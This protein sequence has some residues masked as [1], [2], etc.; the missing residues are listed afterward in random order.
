MARK[1]KAMRKADEDT[2][3]AM[4]KRISELVKSLALRR[5]I[6][7][8]RLAEELGYSRVGFN[9]I[10]NSDSP[11]R[12][13][14]LPGL[15]AISRVFGVPL[16]DVIRVAEGDAKIGIQGLPLVFVISGTEPRT[17]ERLICLVQEALQESPEANKKLMFDEGDA[18]ASLGCRPIELKRGA[19]DFYQGY[20]DGV[21]SDTDAFSKLRSAVKY[22]S[23]HGGFAK[24]PLWVAIGK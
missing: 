15:C 21:I 7:Q 22:V 13:W 24:V 8:A 14:R 10:I 12:L 3:V 23:E 9:Q 6:T 2:A 5:G 19:S 16:S 4:G 1:S 11:S 20:I 18:E 17:E